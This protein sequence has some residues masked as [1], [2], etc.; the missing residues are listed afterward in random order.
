[1]P[2]LWGVSFDATAM[3]GVVV[4]FVKTAELFAD[5]GY[6]IHLDLGYDIKADKGPFFRP[7]SD[8]RVPRRLVLDRVN[9]LDRI[10]GYNRDF[11]TN[12]LRA[13]QRNEVPD[14]S[15]IAPEIAR[16]IEETWERLGVTMVMVENGTLPEN[17]AYTTALYQ[18]I[19][20][21]GAR[22]ALGRFVFW[23]DHDMMWQSEPGKYGTSSPMRTPGPAWRG[24]SPHRG[25]SRPTARSSRTTATAGRHSSSST[26]CAR[27]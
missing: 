25:S 10:A 5:R 8:E 1:M 26:G 24:S 3:S 19:E 4:E 18:A 23:R 16:K 13:V 11:V 17:V 20:R 7:Y 27:C 22:H 15:D 14:I 9:G 12:T 2:A 21:Y 6:R